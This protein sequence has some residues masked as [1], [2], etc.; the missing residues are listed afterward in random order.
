MGTR[1]ES[2]M[3]GN[4]ERRIGGNDQRKADGRA[5]EF[6][7]DPDFPGRVSRKQA[8]R[9]GRAPGPELA[10]EGVVSLSGFASLFSHAS[11]G[12]DRVSLRM[13]AKPS[14][15]FILLLHYATPFP[16]SYPR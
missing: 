16:S 10:D 2:D 7:V 4:D 6:K 15:A 14:D 1:K 5:A 13:H 11:I 9:R 3:N 12:R 8:G